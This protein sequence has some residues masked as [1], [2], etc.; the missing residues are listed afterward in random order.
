VQPGIETKV[1][2][3]VDA[4]R[5]PSLSLS[6]T[7][8]QHQAP[9]SSA[10]TFLIAGVAAALGSLLSCCQPVAYEGCVPGVFFAPLFKGCQMP[11]WPALCWG[12]TWIWGAGVWGGLAS[13]MHLV[14]SSGAAMPVVGAW[15]VGCGGANPPCNFGQ[16]SGGVTPMVGLAGSH[17]GIDRESLPCISL[18]GHIMCCAL[19]GL[20]G[21]ACT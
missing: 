3:R 5:A 15:A 18:L 6:R 19:V 8:H 16:I 20:T 14:G 9:C 13:G 17:G 2:H 12:C 10:C 11:G 1:T 4:T 7:Q 21:P